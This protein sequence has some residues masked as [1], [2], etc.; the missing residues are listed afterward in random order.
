ML[1]PWGFSPAL[2]RL[3]SLC[4]GPG[5][6]RGRRRRAYHFLL[7]QRTRFAHPSVAAGRSGSNSSKRRALRIPPQGGEA[8]GAS[9]VLPFCPEGSL[10][11]EEPDTPRN[12]L[13]RLYAAFLRTLA[14]FALDLCR[15]QILAPML[16]AACLGS[17]HNLHGGGVVRPHQVLLGGLG[18]LLQPPSGASPGWHLSLGEGR[19]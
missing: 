5:L 4:A 1:L 8:Q 11:P 18:G 15:R 10:A 2:P 13:P 16:L 3:A 19:G 12:S 7:T 17:A 9:L 14:I 6:P